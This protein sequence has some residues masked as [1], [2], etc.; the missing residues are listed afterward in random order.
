M[1][2]Y[3][4]NRNS[5]HLLKNANEFKQNCLIEGK[6]LLTDAVIWTSE[7]CE[8]LTKYFVD[9]LMQVRATFLQ[10]LKLS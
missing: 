1:P 6:S 3:C 9:N 2:R 10:S 8:E 4:G 5:E 7:Y